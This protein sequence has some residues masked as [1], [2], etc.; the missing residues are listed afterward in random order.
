MTWWEVEEMAFY[1]S[2]AEEALDEWTMS[3]PQMRIEQHAVDRI[4]VKLEKMRSKINNPEKK[5]FI[6]NLANRVEGLRQH[7]TE[8]LKRDI[9]SEHPVLR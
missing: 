6:E 4:S 3:G 9:P 8:R 2:E 7:L 5:V 1:V